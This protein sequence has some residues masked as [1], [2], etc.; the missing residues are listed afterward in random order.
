MVKEDLE[1]LLNQLVLLKL[2]Q[3]AKNKK[4]EDSSSAFFQYAKL[5]YLPPKILPSMLP[6]PPP[7]CCW[8]PPPPSTLPKISFSGLPPD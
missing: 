2:K 8:P 4:A 5:N 1:K 3:K 6:N 7:C